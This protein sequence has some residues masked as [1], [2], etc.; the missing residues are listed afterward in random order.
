MVLPVSLQ[1]ESLTMQLAHDNK[2][3]F[4]R[5]ITY[6]KERLPEPFAGGKIAQEEEKKT[7][8]FLSNQALQNL[9]ERCEGGE[10]W[11]EGC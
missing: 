4:R 1:F 6:L 8:K 10:Q 9:G 11:Q 2:I 5:K 7:I 3:S